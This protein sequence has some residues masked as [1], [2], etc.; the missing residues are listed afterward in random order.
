MLVVF[1]Q[2]DSWTGFNAMYG[3]MFRC[4]ANQI[5][6][7]TH[8]GTVLGANPL[9]RKLGNAILCPIDLQHRKD[10]DGSFHKSDRVAFVRDLRT[11]KDMPTKLL[12][13]L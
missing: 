13:Q 9:K 10:F 2:R 12:E 3:R 4:N 5:Q 11:R 6:F 8:A 1:Y 7:C